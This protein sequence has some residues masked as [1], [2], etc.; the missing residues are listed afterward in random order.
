[1]QSNVKVVVKGEDSTHIKKFLHY[2]EN[3]Q[4]ST[5]KISQD[6]EEL[7]KMVQETLDE[8]HG[9]AEEVSVKIDLFWYL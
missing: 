2:G 4:N 6:C 3:E 7:A 9:I 1:M 5:L 8:F